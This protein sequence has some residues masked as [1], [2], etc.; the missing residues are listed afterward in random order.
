[1]FLARFIPGF[2]VAHAKHALMALLLASLAACGGGQVDLLAAIPEDD[3]NEVIAVLINEGIQATKVA[4]KEGMVGVS[5]DQTKAAKAVDIMRQ[6]GLPRETFSGMGVVFQ[7]SGLISSPVEERARY[8]Y[9]LSQEL[10]GTLS[11]IDGVLFAR[12]HL[13]L[14][15]RGSGLDRDTSSSAAVFIKH[16]TGADIEILQPQIRRLVVNS[17][18]GLTLDRVS[19]V[20]IPS[21]IKA[22]DNT[23]WVSVW[24][25]QVHPSSEQSL[26][27]MLI[28]LGALLLIALAGAGYLA[29][30]YVLQKS[31]TGQNK[32]SEDG[33]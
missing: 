22:K 11:R 5:V 3:A 31:A 25:V 32:P 4:G 21:N 10:S 2:D 18:P 28:A 17:I 16:Q 27:N 1:M 30:M 19:V 20:L 9:A 26:R 29:R 15:E 24:G 8:L 6:R 33:A 7:K 12:V 13:V 23:P 14:P